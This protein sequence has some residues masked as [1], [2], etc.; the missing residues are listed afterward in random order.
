MSYEL[1]AVEKGSELTGGYWGIWVIR[2]PGQPE[3]M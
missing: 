3:E 1:L 2:A